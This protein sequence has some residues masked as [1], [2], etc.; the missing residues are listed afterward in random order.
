MGISGGI[1]YLLTRLSLVFKAD[2]LSER[3]SAIVDID[4]LN[5]TSDWSP[6]KHVCKCT[7]RLL[8]LLL[9]LVLSLYVHHLFLILHGVWTGC[10]V[11]ELMKIRCAVHQWTVCYSIP[12][13]A[14]TAQ[15]MLSWCRV[16]N[17]T[18]SPKV[19]LVFHYSNR[20]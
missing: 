17:A 2:R 1:Y 16:S 10:G 13:S 3:D 9:L 19:L 7:S 14:A 12:V 8:G 20:A 6:G 15:A 5:F 18:K 11:W 4:N